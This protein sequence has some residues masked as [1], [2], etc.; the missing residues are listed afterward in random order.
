MNKALPAF[1]F[2]LNQQ[3]DHSIVHQ[4]LKDGCNFADQYFTVLR[5]KV[6]NQSSF[7]VIIYN[8]A[9]D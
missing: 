9:F 3:S 4:L 8:N 1:S 6:T 7:E 2:L 5:D